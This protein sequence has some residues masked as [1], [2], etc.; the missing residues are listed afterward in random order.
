MKEVI[1]ITSNKKRKVLNYLWNAAIKDLCVE[2]MAKVF[3]L[4]TLQNAY[5]FFDVQTT[6]DPDSYLSQS[7]PAQVV[8]I[9][10]LL[11]IDGNEGKIV[12][13]FVEIGPGEGKSLTL[14]IASA[15]LALIGFD[16]NCACYSAYLSKRDYKSF[17]ELFQVLGIQQNIHYGTFNQLYVKIWLM[18]K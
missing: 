5:H 17:E 14:A 1:L 10:R 3:A 6:E 18:L 2:L 9:F 4:W 15:V 7:R 12:R 8:P 16:V 13:N 11:N